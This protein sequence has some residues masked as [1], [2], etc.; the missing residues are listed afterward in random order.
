MKFELFVELKG[1]NWQSPGLYLVP[2]SK[3]W[4]YAQV[5]FWTKL[6]FS[7]HSSYFIFQTALRE[8]GISHRRPVLPILI[9]GEREETD[10][11]SAES[12]KKS[13]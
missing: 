5:D 12:D 4:L 8:L 11:F 9:G 6:F 13:V 10:L 1:I 7:S 3:L 2:R